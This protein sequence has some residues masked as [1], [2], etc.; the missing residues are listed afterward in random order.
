MS[1]IDAMQTKD[2]VTENG[3]PAHSTTGQGVLDFFSKSGASRK[4]SEKEILSL[5]QSALS[6]DSLNAKRA[7]FYARDIRGG[8]GERRLFRTILRDLAVNDPESLIN[9]LP[10]IP[11]YGRWDDL[12]V[13]EGTPLEKVAVGLWAQALRDQ[14][15]LAAKWAPRSGPWFAFLRRALELN[16]GDYRRLIA[17]LTKVV[18][19][20][21]CEN[22]WNEI[23]YSHV[24][25]VAS[26][27]YRKAFYRHDQERYKEFVKKAKKGEVKIHSGVLY[28]SDLVKHYFV[29][30]PKKD[31]TVEAQW[32]QLP[33]WLENNE[34]G[35]LPIADVSGSMSGQ[36]MEVSVGLGIYLAERLNG[37]FKGVLCTFSENPTFFKLTGTSLLKNVEIVK[38]AHWGM[39]TDF[40]KVFQILLRRAQ[41]NNVPEHDMPK[42]ILVISD[43]QFNQCSQ[44]PSAT[45]LESIRKQYQSAGYELPEI[46]FW[47]VRA[48]SGQPAKK[49][50]KGVQ[51]VSGY[52]PSIMKS[53][54]ASK[55]QATPLD[56]MYETLEK[57][58]DVV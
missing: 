40:S 44:Y 10:L 56:L 52:S 24:P 45:G 12:M 11:K 27:R 53:I 34:G 29:W 5:F 19:T 37:T 22:E 39:N 54:L 8:Q 4:S 1:F 2:V 28:P 18:E 9:N 23:N 17:R 21:M 33:N 32:T 50:D 3:M 57:Y 13:L 36:P 25:S 15:G 35:I 6:E 58:S 47:N 43:M 41:D 26:L 14:N 7:L 16:A 42:K 46:V 48:S 38:N 20:Q 31:E 49:N 55:P 30:N 51:L